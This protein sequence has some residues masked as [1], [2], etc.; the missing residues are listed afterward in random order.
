M[1]RGILVRSGAVLLGCG[2]S[3]AVRNLPA[4][5]AASHE[6]QRTTPGAQATQAVYVS[7]VS[8][9]VFEYPIEASG[10]LGGAVHVVL[11]K[12][13]AFG[14]NA[15]TFGP[16]GDLFAI[17]HYATKM[18]AYHQNV[19]GAWKFAYTLQPIYHSDS[20][21]LDGKAYVYMSGVQGRVPQAQ[22]Y[23]PNAN[24]IVQ[25]IIVIPGDGSACCRVAMWAE[26]LYISG[27]GIR[28][29]AKPYSAPRLA[30]TITSTGTFGGPMTLD[31]SS[32]LYV[33]VGNAIW[34]YPPTAQGMAH[35]DRVIAPSSGPTFSA[36]SG[37]AV[38]GTTLYVYGNDGS[39]GTLWVMDAT[40]G[41]QTPRQVITGIGTQPQGMAVGPIVPPAAQTR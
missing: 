5:R 18:Y 1:R 33:G 41:S 22:V 24:G 14:P 40:Q 34:A 9:G 36:Q 19:A 16:D 4:Q 6:S 39:G 27:N 38:V 25:P 21:V 37:M 29:Y 32:E 2:G 17:G 7:D 15:L 20:V 30:R 11:P 35:P 10:T 28:V 23:T 12:I 13:G 3:P 26:H 8:G 31:T